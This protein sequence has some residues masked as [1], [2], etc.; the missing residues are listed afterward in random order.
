MVGDNFVTAFIADIHFGALNANSLYHQLEEKF[1]KVIDGKMIDMVVIGG[2]FFHHIITMNYSTSHLSIIFMKNLVE[3]CIKNKI[4]YI[5]VIQGTISHD[6]NQLNN[7]RIYENRVDVSFKIIVTVTEEILAEGIK[8]LYIPEEYMKNPAEYYQ[9]YFD[10][11]KKYDFIF[12]HGMVKEVAFIAKEQLS[13]NTMSKAPVFDTKELINVCKGPIYFGHIHTF[14]NIKN[15]LFYPG[16][17]S[18]FRH[19]EEEPKG[20]FLNVYNTKIHKYIHEFVKNTLAPEYNTVTVSLNKTT[21][22]N[23]DEIISIIN[24]VTSKSDQVRVLLVFTDNDDY[25]YAIRYISDYYHNTPNV[26]VQL[27]D[28]GKEEKIL[29]ER[30]A[31]D[32]TMEEFGFVF[33][34][35]MSTFQKIQ[36]FIKVKKGKNIP[37][38]VIED[39]LSE[40]DVNH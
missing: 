15:H 9:D 38:E 37:I 11:E 23:P 2:D 27:V 13:E 30:V 3:C 4:K 24:N 34:D 10:M 8:I 14:T 16:S 5:R 20:W 17:F 19:G 1:L 12:G 28:M 26:K 31:F 36:K 35:K 33:D 22:E 39:E 7:F 29:E 21:K 25:S 40:L 18:R 6:N 32:N